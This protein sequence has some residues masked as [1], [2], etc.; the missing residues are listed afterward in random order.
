MP[1][2]TIHTELQYSAGRTASKLL[3]YPGLWSFELCMQFLTLGSIMDQDS[4]DLRGPLE[5]A[6][7]LLQQVT[8]Q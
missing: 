7:L 3:Q 1:I 4:L 6:A 5:M 2:R 8:K